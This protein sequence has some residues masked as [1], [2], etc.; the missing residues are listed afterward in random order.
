MK[1]IISK[2]LLISAACFA[3]A[4]Q[5]GGDYLQG[6]GVA[7][8]SRFYVGGSLGAANQNGFEEGS[9]GTGKLLGGMRYGRYLGA[10]IGYTALGEVERTGE[11]RVAPVIKGE[12]D[13]LYAAVMGYM[14]VAHRT[15]LFGK[16]GVMRW[17]SDYEN[18]YSQ[19]DNNNGY[20]DSSSNDSGTSPL[21]GIGAQY[22]MNPNM[23]LRGEWERVISTGNDANES[24]VDLL[25][26]GVTL[27]TF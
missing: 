9:S 13:G 7:P 14:P 16:A 6:W 11:E 18:D 21:I 8:Q 10:E 4:V 1:H 19:D 23:F 22:H 5:A 17:N 3:G 12:T 27:S 24:D 25:T 26:V 15:E 20:D 2:T